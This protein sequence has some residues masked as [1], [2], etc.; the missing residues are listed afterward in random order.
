MRRHTVILIVL[1]ALLAGIVFLVARGVHLVARHQLLALAEPQVIQWQITEALHPSEVDAE[2]WPR[3]PG[4]GPWYVEPERPVRLVLPDGETHLLPPHVAQAWQ[5]EKG[6]LRGLRLI[7][8]P[9]TIREAA[10]EMEDVCRAW[11]IW[12]EED[13]YAVRDYTED[14]IMER[15]VSNHMAIRGPWDDHYVRSV[16]LRRGQSHRDENWHAIVSIA[17]DKQI[18]TLDGQP[19]PK[20][21]SGVRIS[22]VRQLRYDED[23]RY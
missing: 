18:A 11:D 13:F 3:E 8:P 9:V 15:I 12:Q 1:L 16:E 20:H 2:V 4:K 17:F 22:G 21:P 10:Q 23:N 19:L 14:Q 6:R 5:D 7:R